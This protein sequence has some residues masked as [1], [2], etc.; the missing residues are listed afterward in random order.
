M[1]MPRLLQ[2]RR[3][4]RPTCLCIF[5]LT[6]FSCTFPRKE[7][8]RCWILY[9]ALILLEMMQITIMLLMFPQNNF[10]QNYLMVASLPKTCTW[11]DMFV[12]SICV[13][14]LLPLRQPF[15]NL[16]LYLLCY[17]LNIHRVPFLVIALFVLDLLRTKVRS[18]NNYIS[19]P[20]QV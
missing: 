12:K 8:F 2:C 3:Q 18:R 20:L 11:T 19:L 16:Y 14:L 7:E 15:M 4:L 1:V 17:H 9:M 5:L 6:P 13:T 10:R